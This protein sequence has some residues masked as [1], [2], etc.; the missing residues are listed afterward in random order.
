[1]AALGLCRQES[2]GPLAEY[3]WQPVQFGCLG[4]LFGCLG[5]RGSTWAVWGIERQ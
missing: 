1:M 3:E 4:K 5:Q 2:G